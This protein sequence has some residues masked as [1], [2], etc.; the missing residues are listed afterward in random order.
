M[1]VINSHFIL[2]TGDVVSNFQ[3]GSLLEEH[4]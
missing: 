1:A 2:V 3:L 4:K